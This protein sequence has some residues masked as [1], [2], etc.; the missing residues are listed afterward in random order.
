[1]MRMI[2]I[3]FN[4]IRLSIDI[5]LAV[6]TVSAPLFGYPFSATNV[7]IFIKNA[8]ETKERV[9]QSLFPNQTDPKIGFT[10]VDKMRR[11]HWDKMSMGGKVGPPNGSV[12]YYC[13]VPTAHYDGPWG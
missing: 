4:T 3:T 12:Q 11:Q 10:T 13:D 7:Q 8:F 9:R 1:M 6:A 5:E 2:P